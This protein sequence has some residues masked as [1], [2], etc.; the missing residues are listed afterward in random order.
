MA[1]QAERGRRLFAAVAAHHHADWTPSASP[2]F[3]ANALRVGGKIYV[4]LTRSNRLLLKLAPDRV[5]ELLAAGNVER[6]ESG[7]R[8]M[9]G[10]VTLKPDD[11]ELWIALS[12]EARAYAASH[13][14]Q[15][16]RKRKPR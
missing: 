13:A 5:T 7:G 6:F 4:A 3:G 8:V 16:K 9:N 14:K 15:P 12:D 1:D 2:K 11:A 10:W